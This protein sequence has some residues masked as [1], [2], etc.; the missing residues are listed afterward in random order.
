[1]FDFCE[2]LEIIGISGRVNSVEE[3]FFM[4]ALEFVIEQF[5]TCFSY[6]RELKASQ[7]YYH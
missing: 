4:K 1:M 2:C 3:F 6:L 7:H 5:S